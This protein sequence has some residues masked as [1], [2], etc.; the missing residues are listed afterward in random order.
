MTKYIKLLWPFVAFLTVLWTLCLSPPSSYTSIFLWSHTG[1][2]SGKGRKQNSNAF[3]KT[4]KEQRW[5]SKEGVLYTVPQSSSLR[6]SSSPS[7]DPGS[8]CNCVCVCVCVC[9]RMGTCKAQALQ[10]TPLHVSSAGK[11]WGPHQ[12][13]V[14]TLP[15]WKLISDKRPRSSK[16]GSSEGMTAGDSSLD[17]G[18]GHPP[19]RGR[20]V[21]DRQAWGRARDWGSVR[22]P[23]KCQ[24]HELFPWQA[25]PLLCQTSN[26]HGAWSYKICCLLA[27]IIGTFWHGVNDCF[28][29]CFHAGKSQ[30]LCLYR[31]RKCSQY[32]Q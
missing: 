32:S 22:W 1:G 26:I 15:A 28:V 17:E 4:I 9:E 21:T 27:L 11:C 3:I 6:L 25:L 24:R 8:T 12:R 16:G 5:H 19:G 13:A 7:K 18:K 30:I 20:L 29:L 23:F 31:D 2:V 14:L 10:K